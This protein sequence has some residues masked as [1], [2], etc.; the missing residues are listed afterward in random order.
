MLHKGQ[1]EFQTVE[2]VKTKPF[3]RLLIT[4]GLM[5]SSETDEYVYHQSLVHPALAH[6]PEP[7]KVF[8]AGGGEVRFVI[9][10]HPTRVPSVPRIE[11]SGPPHA[12][13]RELTNPNDSLNPGRHPPR[14]A[15]APQRRGVHDGRHR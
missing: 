8:I 15:E 10:Q 6:H 7:K 1:S 9:A 12:L 4:D 2:V 11:R 13:T 3:G 14:G 5:Q